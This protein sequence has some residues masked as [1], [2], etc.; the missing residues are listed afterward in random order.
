MRVLFVP[1]WPVRGQRGGGQEAAN[2]VPRD[3]TYWFFRHWPGPPDVE[4]VDPGA[5][6][7]W[8]F[9]RKYLRFYPLQVVRVLRARRRHDVIVAHGAQSGLGV[10]LLK[11]LGLL[12]RVPLAI[13]DVGA[14]NGGRID[15]PLL[16]LYRWLLERA[17]LIV[18]HA[19]VQAR[20]YESALPEIVDRTVFVP[21]GMDLVD[22]QRD[23]ACTR[24]D[25]YLL[26]MGFDSTSRD[27]TTLLRAYRMSG[28]SIPLKVVGYCGPFEQPTPKGVKLAPPVSLPEVTRLVQGARAVVLPLPAMR[29]AC[30]QQT[31]LQCMLSGKAIVTTRSPAISDYVSPGI[32]CIAGPPGDVEAMS[33]G[34][35]MVAADSDLVVALGRRARRTALAAGGEAAMAASLYRH[36][37]QLLES[38]ATRPP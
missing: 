23:H 16:P 12:G 32:D 3:G 36:V 22:N 2:H 13:I 25:D 6:R 5:E 8:E 4:V 30:G 34:I 19:S 35:K 15:D 11:R 37:A 9:Q 24:G 29:F 28:V 31:L 26:S 14:I 21:F 10:C 1:N 33:T 7:I 17:D 27:W 38:S 20:F 18:Y